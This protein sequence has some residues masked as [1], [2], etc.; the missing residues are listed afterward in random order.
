[1]CRYFCVCRT[2]S[3]CH[4]AIDFKFEHGQGDRRWLKILNVHE[5]SGKLTGF[6]GIS[7]FD[8]KSISLQLVCT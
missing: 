7:T 1:M 6:G 3:T 2:I 5:D 4:L 8:L